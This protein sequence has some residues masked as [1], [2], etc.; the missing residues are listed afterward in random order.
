MP[1]EN[2]LIIIFHSEARILI[3][4]VYWYIS[5][6]SKLDIYR[7][8]L[9]VCMSPTRSVFLFKVTAADKSYLRSSMFDQWCVWTI[10]ALLR[11]E[12][13]WGCQKSKAAL[14]RANHA[15][16]Q[17]G[18][19]SQT[20][21]TSVEQR[22]GLELDPIQTRKQ[23]RCQPDTLGPISYPAQRRVGAAFGMKIKDNELVGWRAIG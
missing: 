13:T 21:L 2:Y 1:I 22:T 12:A 19:D 18:T 6:S 15:Y 3:V 5:P 14:R 20:P 7:Y 11:A 9:V 23:I 4:Q 8:N 16:I 10:G 17:N